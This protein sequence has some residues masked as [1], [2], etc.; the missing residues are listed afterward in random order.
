M[1]SSL[2]PGQVLAGKYR[3]ERELG[4]GGM[5]R[6]FEVTHLQ[7]GERAAIKALRG[8]VA[9]I[10]GVVERF[11]REARAMSRLKSEHVARVQDV[12]QLP[13][14]QP[15]MVMEYLEGVD[16][17]EAISA[18]K[19]FAPQE[20]VDLV[21][22][23]AEAIAEAHARG[24]VHRDLKPSNLF[25]TSRPDGSPVLKLL[26]FG[27][28][29]L[30]A[31]TGAEAMALTHTQ[32]MLGSPLYMAPE[33]IASARDADERA[34]MWGLGTVLYEM[35]AGRPPFEAES[36]RHLQYKILHEP[37]ASIGQRHPGV[38][39]ALEAV[40]LRCLEKDPAR[41]YPDV[42]G[43]ARA[44]GPFA[45]TRGR[46]Y[47]ERVAG[48]VARAHTLSDPNDND[49]SGQPDPAGRAATAQKSVPPRTQS[50]V[51]HF[52]HA[53][54]FDGSGGGTE[55]VYEG[56]QP[57][58]GGTRDAWGGT[59]RRSTRSR[60]GLVAGGLVVAAC[61]AILVV[62]TVRYVSRPSAA[63]PTVVFVGASGHPP[64]PPEALASPNPAPR[65]SPPTDEGIVEAVA[66]VSA[67]VPEVSAPKAAS[68]RNRAP[69]RT[70]SPVR[71]E[72]VSA[73]SSPDGSS[74]P[75]KAGGLFDTRK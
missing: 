65:R 44:L 11:S 10:S 72:P 35:L 33:Q 51:D 22:Q 25:L 63:P 68:A 2:S 74:D 39:E 19:V 57:E 70:A 32:A 15:Y 4:S 12:G 49:R 53:P 9:H 55:K 48:I 75:G 36:L 24:I 69:A 60:V 37:P 58:T 8:D 17:S 23:V 34:D 42:D 29:K 7:L 13:G 47:V 45:S 41:R 52:A 30:A 21:L 6:V 28:S 31:D 43:L 20:A 5:A 50:Y 56:G 38:P 59:H 16:L 18:R 54:T 64:A 14:G 27:I 46:P 61:L 62:A 66:S 3:I 40:V 1:A 73:P 67:D 71:R 26:D